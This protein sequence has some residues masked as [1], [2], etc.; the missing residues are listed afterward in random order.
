MACL[1]DKQHI[2]DEIRRTAAE[3]RGVPLGRRRFAT[4]TRI[5]PANWE[6]KIWARWG[7]AVKEAG[8]APNQF[9]EGYGDAELLT[10]LAGFMREL[11]RYPVANELRMRAR[12]GVAFPNAKTFQRIGPKQEILAKMVALLKSRPEWADVVAMCEPLIKKAVSEEGPPSPGVPV[13]EGY[14]YLIQSGRRYKIGATNDFARRSQAIAVQMPDP[15]DTVH[16]IRT[17]DPFGIEAYWHKRFAYKRTNGEWFDL[18]RD[19]VAAFR[20][21]KTM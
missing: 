10:I 19:E 16:V 21:R 6:G 7:D 12:S 13:R 4:E 18:S 11:G 8:F 9:M 1:M 14:V 17:D 2:I 3:N 20:K 5:E 15:T